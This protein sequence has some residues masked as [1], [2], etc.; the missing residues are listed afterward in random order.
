MLAITWVVLGYAIFYVTWRTWQ[1]DRR[2]KRSKK[3]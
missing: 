2:N 3:H 1:Y